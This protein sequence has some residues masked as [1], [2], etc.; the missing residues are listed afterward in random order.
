MSMTEIRFWE[1]NLLQK[2][3]GKLYKALW[4]YHKLFIDDIHLIT[5]LRKNMKNYLML[6]SDKILLR[7]H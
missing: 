3:Y 1:A 5:K 6:L 7:K 2:I 4:R